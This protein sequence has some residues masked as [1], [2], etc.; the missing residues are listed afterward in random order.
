MTVFRGRKGQQAIRRSAPASQNDLRQPGA[1]AG[2]PWLRALLA[3]S[4][5]MLVG[6]LG[7]CDRSRETTV[8]AQGA[9][10]PS[11]AVAAT[12]GL[13]TA[14]EQGTR[15]PDAD[16]IRPNPL[17][18]AYF[19]NLH[20]HTGWSFDA[21]T[22]GSLT[23]PDDAYRWARGEPIAGAAG[24][25]DL[26]ILKPLDWYA[27]SEHAEYLGVLPLM[28]DE[29]NP[30]S[31]H[32]LAEGIYGGDPDAAF[33]AYQEISNQI[34]GVPPSPD[35]VLYAPEL[36]RTLWGQVVDVANA[37]YQPGEFTTFPAFEWTAA[38]NWQNLHRVVL[39]RDARNLPEMPLTAMDT[40]VPAELWAW[41]KQQRD[42]GAALL[43]VPHNGNA[44]DGLMFPTGEAFGGVTVDAD[45]AKAR[46][47]NEPLFELTQIK[48]TSEVFPTMNPNDEF[49]DF[50]I[51][52]YTL[53][54]DAVPPS[55]R[56]GGY[57]REALIRG[58]KYAQEGRHNPFK[59][60]FIGD[61]DTHNAAA[62][63][64]EDNYTGKFGFEQEPRHRLEGP[65]GVPES[66]I[67]QVQRFS[68]GGVAGV[69]AESNT[70]EAI[71]DAMM[72][73]ETFATSGPR[74]KVR[75]FAG[76]DYVDDLLETA[77]WLQ[78]AYARGVPMGGDLPAATDGVAPTFLVAAT[79][80]A[81]GANLDRIQIVK[82]WI[83]NGEQ[84][85]R[86]YDVALSDGRSDGGVAV[87]NTVDVATASYT[88]DIGAAQL[89]AS[90]TDPDFDPAVPALYYARVL[91]IPTPRW[92]TYDAARLG[93]DVPEGLP[94][95][96]QERAWTSPI[97]Y[98]PA[99]S[100]SDQDQAES[101]Q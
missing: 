51:W 35:P 10:P 101:P 96:I 99:G 61:S 87:G 98:S 29:S 58:M 31:E 71:F 94:K 64:E 95:A 19:G 91:Q 36:R 11:E 33:A 97:W 20:V 43:A 67:A 85:E 34:Y 100:A 82:G 24:L 39:F 59:F 21:T 93:I 70:R 60:G 38:P 72:R 2:G 89:L 73:R 78:A 88:N 6:F 32:P 16:S 27:V 3:S 62:S 84:S 74:L 52:D 26:R 68:S 14:G 55:R 53:S 54:P 9:Q 8:T 28:A 86:I 50:E 56:R 25:P 77:D 69:W 90:W 83:E 45:Y 79:K 23:S 17:R 22:N 57:A 63:I 65:P 75:M 40:S 30:L 66:A 18:E 41:M 12:D 7:G 15:G 81:E 49:A 13:G 80:E 92:S 42:N 46:T 4:A 48:G 5:V 47:R 1:T 76:Y 44:S 37:H